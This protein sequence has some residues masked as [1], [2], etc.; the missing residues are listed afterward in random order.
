MLFQ[1]GFFGTTKTLCKAASQIPPHSERTVM[2][3][4][5]RT[6]F[7]SG[8]CFYLIT[9]SIC[10]M[11]LTICTIGCDDSDRSAELVLRFSAIPDQ[12]STELQ[13]KFVQGQQGTETLKLL[14][15]HS[16]LHLGQ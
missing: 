2:R 7:L 16:I 8:S 10:L 4:R 9:K 15:E 11:W 5:H 12:N 3:D 13:E 6:P 14:L 1:K